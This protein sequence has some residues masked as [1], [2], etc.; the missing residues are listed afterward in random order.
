MY[1][2]YCVINIDKSKLRLQIIRHI[3]SLLSQGERGGG[4]DNPKLEKY[5]PYGLQITD[6]QNNLSMPSPQLSP[7]CSKLTLSPMSSFVCVWMV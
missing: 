7:D 3:S 2:L 1:P 5:Q 4:W 6:Q